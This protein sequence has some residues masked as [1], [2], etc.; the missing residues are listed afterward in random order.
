MWPQPDNVLPFIEKPVASLPR[1]APS[2]VNAKELGLTV[3]AAGS[4]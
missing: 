2:L 4:E 1:A 3:A